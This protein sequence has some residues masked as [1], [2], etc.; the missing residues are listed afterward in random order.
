[1]AVA[2]RVRRFTVDEYERML[3]AGVLAPDVHVELI[4]GEVVDMAPIGESGAGS[5][6]ECICKNQ[7]A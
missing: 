2:P 5:W 7:G 6:P 3:D 1:M 4:E